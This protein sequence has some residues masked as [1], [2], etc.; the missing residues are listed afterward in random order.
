MPTVT[1]ISYTGHGHP[2]PLYAGRLLAYTK[3]TRM[4]M[5]P[6]GFDTF[7][8]K[9]EQE[10]LDELK[11]MA[12]TIPSSW[13][14]A[15]LVFS[16]NG[17]SRAIAQQITR[18]RQASYA[19]QSQ[20]VTNMKDVSWD[21]PPTTAALQRQHTFNAAM[22]AGVNNYTKLVDLGVSLEDARDVLP[23]GVHCNLIAKYNLR[24]LVELIGKRDSMRVQGPY[25]DVARQ[26]RA[27][28]LQVWPWAEAFFEPK[29]DKALAMIKEVAEELK[30]QGAVYQGPAGKLAKAMDLLK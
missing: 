29:Y 15:D 22:T 12:G 7:M 9:P 11:Y 20:R 19:M 30:S 14:M 26:M 2:D 17:V 16:I 28:T 8:L 4:N 10:I 23:I 5:T 21:A 25:V 3:N 6:A 13:E 27:A 24:T 18:T 1:L